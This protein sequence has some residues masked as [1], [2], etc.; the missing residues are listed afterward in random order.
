MRA[1]YRNVYISIHYY[2]W[3]KIR[4]KQGFIGH[5]STYSVDNAEENFNAFQNFAYKSID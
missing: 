4:Q 1:N 3:M 5:L 2:E